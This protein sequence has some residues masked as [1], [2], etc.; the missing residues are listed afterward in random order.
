MELA[1]RVE[2]GGLVVDV[3]PH[4]RRWDRDLDDPAD[5]ET[6]REVV[7]CARTNASL[8]EAAF[9][10]AAWDDVATLADAKAAL[11]LSAVS[12]H[13]RSPPGT[14]GWRN[15]VRAVHN[16]LSGVKGELCAFPT[17]FLRGETLAPSL[18]AKLFVG[19]RLFQ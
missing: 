15:E 4:Q 7:E 9:D 8:V 5:P 18:L 13:V 14:D 6:W 3:R 16:T 10:L 11:G 1:P 17:D 12:R 2:D 19:R